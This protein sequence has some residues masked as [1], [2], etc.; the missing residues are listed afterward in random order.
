MPSVGLKTRYTVK[1]FIMRIPGTSFSD[2]DDSRETYSIV[3]AYNILNEWSRRT[4]DVLK[5]QPHEVNSDFHILITLDPNP[6]DYRGEDDMKVEIWRS[7]R[8]GRPEK[9]LVMMSQR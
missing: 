1:E 6:T 7:S 3:E 4:V 9:N 8:D 2:T 5:A